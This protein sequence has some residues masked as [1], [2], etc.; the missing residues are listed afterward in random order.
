MRTRPKATQ[1]TWIARRA[2]GA[3]R[4]ARGELDRAGD[5]DAG[6]EDGGDRARERA[7]AAAAAAPARA[8][9]LQRP[10]GGEAEGDAEREGELA[11]GEQGDDA[12]REPEGRP[13]RA[14]SPQ[15]SRTRR[16]KR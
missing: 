14:E 7:A 8:P 11:V 5:E 1:A 15:R 2:E 6:E 10:Q 16:S 3:P 12:G 4:R 13:A 9:A